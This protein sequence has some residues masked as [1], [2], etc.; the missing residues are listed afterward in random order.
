MYKPPYEITS[1]I[2][3]LIQ[4]IAKELGFLQGAKIKTSPLYLRKKN[5]IKTIQS[6]LSIE[7][8]SLSIDQMT[9]LLEGKRIIAPE[10]D[11]TEVQ[12]AIKTYNIINQYNPLLCQ[13][14]LK[15]HKL[16]MASLIADNGRWREISVG[17]IKGDKIAHIAPPAKRVPH[18]INALFEFINYNNNVPW[19]IKACIFHYELEFIHPFSDGNGRIGRLWQ[20]LILMKE[21]DIFEYI[22]IE[23]LV[24]NKQQEY[25]DV[26]SKCDAVGNSTLFIEFMLNQILSSLQIYSSNIVSEINDPESRI[27]YAQQYFKM[28]WFSRKQYILLHKNIS[29][30]TASRDLKQGIL[31][32]HLISNG[33]KNQTLY[34]FT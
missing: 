31:D 33:T 1:L 20:Q 5:K 16:M 29:S 14:L 3:R 26:L 32:G 4:Q 15:A 13:D 10:K 24:K 11:I 27:L 22:P 7:G 17:I 2:L 19:L 30:A 6:S 8:N 21:D 9:A 28:S 12:N 25:Y 23:T 18:L 34:K